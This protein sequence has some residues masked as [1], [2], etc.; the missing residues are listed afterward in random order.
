MT[1]RR[2]A[3]ESTCTDCNALVRRGVHGSVGVESKI[4][5]KREQF[6][7]TVVI[8][9]VVGVI[10]LVAGNTACAL[11]A[12]FVSLYVVAGGSHFGF[13]AEGAACQGVGADKFHAVG[14]IAGK[15]ESRPF[16]CRSDES[17]SIY[18]DLIAAQ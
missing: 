9:D 7:L 3:C 14:F 10:Y 12:V 8:D 13:F 2:A 16:I 5:R 15:A 1:G 11:S 6:G 4:A 18:R 17:L